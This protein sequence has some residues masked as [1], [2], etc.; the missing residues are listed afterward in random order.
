MTDKCAIAAIRRGEKHRSANLRDKEA[1]AFCADLDRRIRALTETADAVAA[2]E[3]EQ[4]RFLLGL[5]KMNWPM[6]W[7][8]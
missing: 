8:N 5:P 7:K 4:R 6:F 2:P 1:D 3:N